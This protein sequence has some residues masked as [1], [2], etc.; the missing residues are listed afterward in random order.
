MVAMAGVKVMGDLEQ[1][2]EV[3]PALARQDPGLISIHQPL[4]APSTIQRRPQLRSE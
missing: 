2:L 4:P 1:L 3:F